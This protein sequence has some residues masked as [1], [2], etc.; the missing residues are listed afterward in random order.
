MIQKA[1]PEEVEQHLGILDRDEITTVL[2]ADGSVR[3]ALLHGSR[4]LNAMRANHE[5]GLLETYI[6][7]QAYIAGGLLTT[8][9]KGNDRIS[10]AVEC[11]GPV[12]GLNV[13]A[14]ASGEIRGYLL[15]NPIPVTDTTP[16][17]S[18]D[19]SSFFGPG[20]ITVSRRLEGS[21][22]PVSGQTMMQHGS[23]AK[24]LAVHFMESEQTPTLF[25][26]SIQYDADGMLTGAGGLFL[27]VLPGAEDNILERIETA[28]L[29]MPSLGLWFA[30]RG[31]SVELLETTFGEFSPQIIGTRDI[32]FSCGCDRDRFLEFIGSMSGDTRTSILTEGPFPLQL[33]CHNC[34]TTYSFSKEEVSEVLAEE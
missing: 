9:L 33:T 20:F 27:Q 24:D 17:G 4:L 10:L 16:L 18:F 29:G 7:G 11:G 3:G 2:L 6:L 5:T 21:R 25:F 12:K 30:R 34:N 31:R 8:M 13:D 15:H 14:T 1:L 19:M 26:I 22:Q 28:A 23:I 32:I